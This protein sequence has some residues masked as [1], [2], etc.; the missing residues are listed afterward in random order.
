LIKTPSRIRYGAT[1][2]DSDPLTKEFATL[3]GKAR[4]PGSFMLDSGAAVNSHRSAAIEGEFYDFFLPDLVRLYHELPEEKRDYHS[5]I[6]TIMRR[7][8]N[9]ATVLRNAKPETRDE[10]DLLPYERTI[11]MLENDACPMFRNY[12][13][14]A[15]NNLPWIASAYHRL[16]NDQATEYYDKAKQRIESHLPV[17]RDYEISM[18]YDEIRRV[19]PYRIVERTQVMPSAP[20]AA[21]LSQMTP[22]ERLRAVSYFAEIVEMALRRDENVMESYAAFFTRLEAMMQSPDVA[23]S[24]SAIQEQYGKLIADYLA[25]LETAS[26]REHERITLLIAND[27]KRPQQ[28]RLDR[29]KPWGEEIVLFADNSAP[30]HLVIKDPFIQGNTL[31]YFRSLRGWVSAEYREQIRLDSIDLETFQ[32]KQ[33]T[34]HS[35][36]VYDLFAPTNHTFFDDQNAYFIGTSAMYPKKEI[37]VFPLNGGNP[38]TVSLDSLPGSTIN[39]ACSFNGKLYFV[40]NERGRIVWFIEFD[41]ETKNYE[42]LS[43]TSAREGKAPFVNVSPA[44]HFYSILADETGNRLLLYLVDARPGWGG[45]WSMDGETGAFTHHLVRA[46]VVPGRLPEYWRLVQIHDESDS[47][48]LT[49]SDYTEIIDLND[50]SIKERYP[51]SG[52]IL[53]QNALWG[54]GRSGWERISLESDAQPERLTLPETIGHPR[55]ILPLKDGSGMVVGDMDSL[56][57]LRFE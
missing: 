31:Y 51:M 38:Q 9:D 29:S 20:P 46:P 28:P 7:F 48:S 18:L 41:K 12:A 53:F 23:I 47:A 1:V 42:I 17:R 5:G 54:S 45:L 26:P 43:S 15:R 55:H 40:S 44:P 3:A 57:L 37:R 56:V 50:S 34:L 27:F 11:A 2:F 36:N 10:R 30:G 13:W 6:G 16:T 19:I 22:A 25:L 24:P 52:G 33:G 39:I 8:I 14:I 49:N 35:E 4:D 21:Q 32:I